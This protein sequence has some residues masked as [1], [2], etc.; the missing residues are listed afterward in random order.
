[1]C[2]TVVRLPP[3][4]AGAFTI[5]NVGHVEAERSSIGDL[6]T[7]LNA[8]NQRITHVNALAADAADFARLGS[9]LDAAN[10]DISNINELTASTASFT[11]LG[12]NLDAQSQSITDVGELDGMLWRY[13]CVCERASVCVVL[14]TV[15]C[16]NEL[17]PAVRS[18]LG[19]LLVCVHDSSR[20]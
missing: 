19:N 9:D 11:A 13:G 15:Q 14:Y 3:S 4:T 20:R 16:S 6:V 7:N 17:T 2:V 1:M 8:G 18:A 5:N 10:N 12:A